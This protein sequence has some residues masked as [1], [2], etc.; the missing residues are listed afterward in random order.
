MG[1]VSSQVTHDSS[2]RLMANEL[3]HQFYIAEILHISVNQYLYR[4]G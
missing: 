1:S 4:Q 2:L 3:T